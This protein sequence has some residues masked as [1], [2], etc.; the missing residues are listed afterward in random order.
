MTARDGPARR[1]LERV[2]VGVVPDVERASEA[3]APTAIQ[4]R[5]MMPNA[6]PLGLQT[7]RTNVPTDP[8]GRTA[9]LSVPGPA[10][11]P[12]QHSGD[13]PMLD[14]L[15]AMLT[16]LQLTS[17]RDQLDSLFDEAAAPTCRRAR[18]WRCSANGR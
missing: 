7:F 5:A 15:D 2:D 12:N 6:C 10:S 13:T 17:I 4:M 16:R 3:A 9:N 1:T 8:Q 11:Q 18:R 14:P